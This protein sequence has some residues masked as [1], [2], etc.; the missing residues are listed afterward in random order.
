MCIPVTASYGIGI[1]NEGFIWNNMFLA[2]GAVTKIHPDGFQE[3]GFPVSTGGD[4][5]RGLAVTP[6]DNNVW[7]ANSGSGTVSRLNANG[8]LLAVIPVGNTP[9]GVA[10]DKAGKVWVTNRLSDNVMRIDPA[11]NQ[12]DL[13]VPLGANA[14]PYNYSDM[15]GIIRLG[16]PPIGFWDV[17]YDGGCNALWDRISWNGQEN[18]ATNS[19]I[20]VEVRVAADK[21]GLAAV[22]FRTVTNGEDLTG[23]KGQFMEVRATLT[24]EAAV[25]Q[26]SLPILHDLTVQHHPLE[27]TVNIPDQKYSFGF[28]P[29][30]LDDFIAFNP[31]GDWFNDVVWSYSPLPLGWSV[32]ID[33]NHVATVT[34]PP[35][36]TRDVPITFSP[37]LAWS[38]EQ[39]TAEGDQVTFFANHPPVL[40][41]NAPPPCLRQNNQKMVAVPLTSYVCDPD[42]DAVTVHI[43]SIT[44]DEPTADKIGDKDAPDASGIGTDTASLRQERDAHSDGRVYVVTFVASDGRGGETTLTLPFAVPHNQTGCEAVDSG[45]NYDAT[46]FSQA[47]AKSKGKK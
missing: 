26:R 3:N 18:A 46:G 6:K 13:T 8:K 7:S 5:G 23:M 44:S 28:A 1:S 15:T 30:D 35:S 31:T 17:V 12:V 16:H 14:Q 19:A 47:P 25:G 29:F 11:T 41:P 33:A 43:T 45:Q 37:R 22:P 2:S 9:T 40:C 34:G 32:S 20:K 36:E 42:G 27:M 4:L 38:S 39:C 10:V 24:T 21:A